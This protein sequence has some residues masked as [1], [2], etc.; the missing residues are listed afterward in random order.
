MKFK[1]E[2]WATY[3]NGKTR[4]CLE[5]ITATLYFTSCRLN[6]WSEATD[7]YFDEEIQKLEEVDM[8]IRRK[9]RH[10]ILFPMMDKKATNHPEGGYSDRPDGT[11]P[12]DRKL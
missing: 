1:D 3:E 5:A 4:F 7:G 12:V 6:E 9:N 10:E 8:S 2:Y 11:S